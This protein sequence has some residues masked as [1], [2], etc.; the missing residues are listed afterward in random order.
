MNNIK[1][2]TKEFLE[3][4][5]KFPFN[6]V[7]FNISDWIVLSKEAKEKLKIEFITLE[8]DKF[9]KEHLEFFRSNEYQ[10]KLNE[11]RNCIAD[12]KKGKIN[13]NCKYNKLIKIYSI[14]N[15]NLSK[16]E[17]DYQVRNNIRDI[18]ELFDLI[19]P[20]VV[21]S[22]NNSIIKA[23]ILAYN[24]L[25]LEIIP[26]MSDELVLNEVLKIY[27][28]YNKD[29]NSQEV[30]ILIDNYLKKYQRYFEWASYRNKLRY[31]KE[32]KSNQKRYTMFEKLEKVIEI[33]NGNLTD[34][35]KIYKI[36]NVV[37]N[38]PDAIFRIIS[39]FVIT[40][41]D[42]PLIQESMKVYLFVRSY[43]NELSHIKETVGNYEKYNSFYEYSKYIIE[44]YIKDPYSYQTSMFYRRFDIDENIFNYCVNTIITFDDDLYD[45]YLEKKNKNIETRINS[46]KNS[47][48]DIIYGI[49]NGYFKDGVELSP[50]EFLKRAPLK[51]Y[52]EC[53]ETYP[54]LRASNMENSHMMSFYHNFVRRL[55]IYTRFA[56][57]ENDDLIKNYASENN[58]DQFSV[59][60]IDKMVKESDKNY[61]VIDYMKKNHYPMIYGIYK[62]ILEKV[63]KGE[64][65]FDNK[66]YQK[67]SNK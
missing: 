17:K 4:I 65:T 7:G 61:Q 44:K 63:N 55:W 41:I 45:K 22:Y 35:E 43:K 26:N 5:N 38:E 67:K 36:I 64:I 25:L 48:E 14:V 52:T 59:Y 34:Y 21:T 37:G 49:K 15:S 62:I 16:Y 10:S 2:E 18:D 20:F 58:I 12:A 42:D 13:P 54:D 53:R 8:K 66:T 51:F 1:Q 29:K 32:H 33:Y 60:K 6:Q 9:I 23:S 50:E 11:L 3:K 19:Y 31:F 27:E 57:K 46:V 24:D 39:P 30:K 40:Y 28:L 56:L 47:M